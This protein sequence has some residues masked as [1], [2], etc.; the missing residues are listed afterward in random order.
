MKG[1]LYKDFK[2]IKRQLAIIGIFIFVMFI[3]VATNKNYYILPVLFMLI[4]YVITPTI[5]YHDVQS[6][7]SEFIFAT[8]C[9]KRDYVL[10]KYFPAFITAILSL[11][12]NVIF[13]SFSGMS[14]QDI[15]LIGTIGFSLPL[16]SVIFLIPVILK[17]GVEKG[18]FL[19]VFFYFI[20]FA[21][22]NKARKIIEL[23]N[24]LSV[25][26]QFLT[27][28][29]MGIILLLLTLL[30]SAVSIFISVKIIKNEDF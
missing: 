1:L 16:L 4:S 2:L 29:H 27:I 10:S 11:F 13:S 18:K 8:P 9:T 19:M 15:I 12:V 17:F 23:V 3:N 28:Y 21:L 6:N 20:I 22:I 30:I 7:F 26:F 5:I 25:R 14:L 24:E